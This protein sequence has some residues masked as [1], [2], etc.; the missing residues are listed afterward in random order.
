LRTDNFVYPLP[1]DLNLHV[2]D[3]S[4]A[5]PVHPTEAVG[6]VGAG[7][8]LLQA[9]GVELYAEV[10]AVDQITIAGDGASDLPPE[11]R[12]RLFNEF[13]I[14]IDRTVS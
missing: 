13:T 11:I 6:L 7:D 4:V 3:Q 1:A 12:L 5:E 8:S 2:L 9:N 10:H 14:L